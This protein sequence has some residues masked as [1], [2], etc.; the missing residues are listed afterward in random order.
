MLHLERSRRGFLSAKIN[1]QWLHSPYAPEREAD[2]FLL[3]ALEGHPLPERILILGTGLGYL[4]QA[5]RRRYPKLPCLSISYSRE[6]RQK[7]LE[8]GILIPEDSLVAADASDQ[9]RSLGQFFSNLLPGDIKILTWNP[10]AKAFPQLHEDMTHTIRDILKQ[11]QSSL[12]TTGYFGYRWLRNFVVNY[13]TLPAVSRNI[14]LLPLDAP[15]I[16][17]ASGPTLERHLTSLAFH[18]SRINLWALPSASGA[19]RHAGIRPDAVLATDPGF[20]A[21]YHYKEILSFQN[22]PPLLMPLTAYPLSPG[23]SISG[24]QHRRILPVPISQ[25]TQLENQF[26]GDSP[27][28]TIPEN[29]TV[30]G[31][32]LHL[33][34]ILAPQR[35]IAFCGLDFSWFDL[36]EH[37]RPHPFDALLAQHQVRRD[38]LPTLIYHRAAQLGVSRTEPPWK[39]S[40]SM[41]RYQAWFSKRLPESP[42]IKCL[43][44]SSPS[45]EQLPCITWEE[46][47]SQPVDCLSDAAS[48]T[49]PVFPDFKQRQRQV[50]CFLDRIRPSSTSTPTSLPEDLRWVEH[51]LALPAQLRLHGIHQSAGSSPDV[52]SRSRHTRLEIQKTLDRQIHKLFRTAQNLGE[53]THAV[54]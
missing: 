15:L 30:A 41:D 40:Q 27:I 13:L 43:S 35:P 33:A 47:L 9:N 24:K 45:S 25:G 18:R 16:I 3:H 42:R 52:N 28:T 26:Y 1:N 34:E 50:L 23:S 32:A 44:P 5:L 53:M 11:N 8:E 12:M 51:W 37:A 54:S 4:H 22:P 36:Q 14:N 21:G 29:G 38:P 48:L 20:Y 49:T 10:A 39:T 6:L 19:L 31:S 2:R 46:L 7:A 17:A